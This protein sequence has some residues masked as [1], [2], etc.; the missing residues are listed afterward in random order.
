[1]LA[2]AR[3]RLA[4]DRGV[5][6]IMV[7]LVFPMLLLCAALA[8]DASRWWVINRHMQ[9]QADA[10]ALAAGS[11]MGDDPLTCTETKIVNRAK[12]YAGISALVPGEAA[13]Q[14]YNGAEDVQTSTSTYEPNFRFNTAGYARGGSPDSDAATFEGTNPCVSG[15]ADVKLSTVDVPWLLSATGLVNTINAHARVQL[16]T[17]GAPKDAAPFGLETT[18]YKRLWVELIDLSDPAANPAPIPLYKTDGTQ[19]SGFDLSR[20]G[21]DASGLTTNWAN[22]ATYNL[23]TSPPGRIGVR[24]RASN[25]NST[26]LCSSTAVKCLGTG[27]IG[28]QQNSLTAVRFYDDPNA[29]GSV[30]VRLGAV[31]MAAIPTAG[32]CDVP[33]VS[34]NLDDGFFNT[35]CNKVTV[36]AHLAGLT[37]SLAALLQ[38]VV[39]VTTS[40]GTTTLTYVPGSDGAPSFDPRWKGDVPIGL[41]T[42]PNEMSVSWEQTGGTITKT[43]GTG[44]ITCDTTATNPCKG[45]IT[46]AHRSF[47]GDGSKTA[48]QISRVG[49]IKHLAISVGT[50]PDQLSNNLKA[51]TCSAAS[52]CPVTVTAGVAGSIGL[53]KTTDPPVVLRAGNSGSGTGL[54]DCNP[55]PTVSTE[56]EVALGCPPNYRVNDDFDCSVFSS[57]NQLL[58]STPP[59]YCAGTES[60]AKVNKVPDGINQRTQCVK[61]PGN[62]PSFG[63]PT[64]CKSHNNWP[65][66]TDDDP[67]IVQ[68]F[69]VEAGSSDLSGGQVFPILGFA[70]FYLT[71]WYGNICTGADNE[72]PAAYSGEKG[73]LVGRWVSYRPP[74]ENNNDA[75]GACN[76]NS[77]IICVPILVK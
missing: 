41:K 61:F 69:L 14:R 70:A 4:D 57:P 3:R 49:A 12:Q 24:V 36:T 32:T 72:F 62:C 39:K 64:Q 8:I 10:A 37:P 34:N 55:T 25:A 27:T 68:V 6:T 73:T 16:L 74:N 51:G 26:V 58:S 35:T 50:G 59:W 5:V 66:Y 65:N 48:P 11:Q 76:L 54:L 15:I 43:G 53:S 33:S 47:S 17:I 7:A 29:V 75:N 60:G 13:A 28:S 30:G 45:T 22:T 56:E 46:N 77:P 31:D 9:T 40:L 23:R 18:D 38:P 1:M 63:N 44:I 52:P 19:V 2:S 42:G 71:G 21:P 20:I 67:R